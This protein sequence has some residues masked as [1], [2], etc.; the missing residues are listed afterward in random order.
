MEDCFELIEWISG[1]TWSNGNVGMYGKSWGGFNGLQMAYKQPPALKTVISLYST[2]NRYTDDVHYEGGA[3][4]ANGMLSWAG[5]M[6][7]LDARPP[8][9]RLV[10]LLIVSE[11]IFKV[12][13]LFCMLLCH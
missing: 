1:Q 6:M 5:T 13:L 10:V 12:L 3:I 4:I 8:H 2:D 9:P 7:A 11:S